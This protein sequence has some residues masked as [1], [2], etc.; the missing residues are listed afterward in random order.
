MSNSKSI[1]ITGGSSGIGEA[2]A[3]MFAQNGADIAI[4]YKSNKA[5][6]ESVIEKAKKFGVKAI[7]VQADL[8]NEKDAKAT[9]EKVVKE[10]GKIDVLVNNAGR[11]VDGDEWNGTSDIWV[12]SLQQNLV[13]MM[14]ISK[15]V[16]ERFQKQKSG[17]IVSIASVHGL[18]GQPDAISYA[19]AKAGVIN[20]TQSYA[21]LLA[22]FGRANSVS[23]GAANAGYWLTAPKEELDKKL[24]SRPNH[25]LVEPENI[26][27]KA[28]FLASDEAKDINGQNF[29]VN[30]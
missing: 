5:G 3:I 10:F 22:P 4:T 27:E 30:E 18:S 29:V 24:A 12:K 13:S 1:L 7:A 20:I 15:Y 9:V 19:A 2:T 23:P 28:V 21:K 11:Y 14:N 6:A 25:K 8:I 17:V 16:I 26:A